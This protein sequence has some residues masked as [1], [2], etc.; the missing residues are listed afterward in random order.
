MS[1]HEQIVT[2]FC[3]I[4]KYCRPMNIRVISYKNSIAAVQTTLYTFLS[5]PFSVFHTVFV[6][7]RYFHVNRM[8]PNFYGFWGVSHYFFQCDS[9][10]SIKF[11][12][13]M[14]VNA[15]ILCRY[16]RPRSDRYILAAGVVC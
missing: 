14:T 8:L 6:R 3:V 5:L 9:A 2:V 4:V 1:R 7:Y 16:P 15:C 13:F 10:H 11:K 12:N